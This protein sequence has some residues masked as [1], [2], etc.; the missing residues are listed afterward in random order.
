[1]KS[2][3][4]TFRPLYSATQ[5]QTAASTKIAL[6]VVIVTAALFIGSF[7]LI[8]GK[9]SAVVLNGGRIFKQPTQTVAQKPTVVRNKQLQAVLQPF[10]KCTPPGVADLD[11]ADIGGLIELYNTE[12]TDTEDILNYIAEKLS[13]FVEKAQAVR[14][15]PQSQAAVQKAVAECMATIVRSLD[16]V[17]VQEWRTIDAYDRDVN[18]Q[19]YTQGL[20]DQ[21]VLDELTRVH[22]MLVD[23]AMPETDPQKPRL[24]QVDS[25]EEKYLTLAASVASANP[26][27]LKL[28]PYLFGVI[29]AE[30]ERA[31]TLDVGYR[32]DAAA[33]YIAIRPLDPYLVGVQRLS[34]ALSD[35]FYDPNSGDLVLKQSSPLYRETNVPYFVNGLN[36]SHKQ[37]GSYIDYDAIITAQGI[38]QPYVAPNTEVGGARYARCSAIRYTRHIVITQYRYTPMTY[39]DLENYARQL[40]AKAQAY[41]D[42]ISSSYIAMALQE[43][44]WPYLEDG[45]QPGEIEQIIADLQALIDVLND[46]KD[47]TTPAEFYAYLVEVAEYLNGISDGDGGIGVTPRELLTHITETLTRLFG[48][49]VFEGIELHDGLSEEEINQLRENITGVDRECIKVNGLDPSCVEQLPPLVHNVAEYLRDVKEVIDSPYGIAPNQPSAQ[50]ENYNLCRFNGLTVQFPD[51][52]NRPEYIP[53]TA[54]YD[55]LP[56]GSVQKMLQDTL[57]SAALL[58]PLAKQHTENA[59]V[60]EALKKVEDLKALLPIAAE[61]IDEYNDNREQIIQDAGLRAYMIGLVTAIYEALESN[62]DAPNTPLFNKLYEKTIGSGKTLREFAADALDGAQNVT[63]DDVVALITAIANALQQQMTR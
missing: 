47:V 41:K 53:A 45:L 63:K 43:I 51:D 10:T 49:D 54:K 23:Q 30:F 57:S 2:A 62:P 60:L 14:N 32:I 35:A 37:V 22:V 31:L 13:A 40:Q 34:K 24:G 19:L 6:A 25:F 46:I 11:A 8:F 42:I 58:V 17:V 16:K 38:D 7:A 18:A 33:G 50:L 5:T 48:S 21:S 15:D 9:S 3:T 27:A 61:V 39:V 52:V 55:T 20:T 28:F 59:V 36:Y 56:T 29:T 4:H 44:L 1:M 26:D 12:G